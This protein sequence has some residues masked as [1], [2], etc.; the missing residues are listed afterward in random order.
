[1][2]VP[3]QGERS[4]GSEYPGD[5]PAGVRLADPVKC[6][7]RDGEVEDA[8]PRPVF[9]GAGAHLDPRIGGQL[10]PGDRGELFAKLDAENAICSASERLRRL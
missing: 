3:K 10:A 1:M 9:E 7:C 4:F 8:F 5:L 2:R 6:F